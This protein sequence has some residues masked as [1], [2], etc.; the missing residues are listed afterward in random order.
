MRRS[1]LTFAACSAAVA[2]VACSG[3]SPTSTEVAATVG[4]EPDTT[5]VSTSVLASSAA[6]GIHKIAHV[7]VIMQENRSF[8]TYFGTYPGADGIP[9]V[10]G[11]PTVCLPSES[12]LCVAPFHDSADVNGG[13]P[14]GQSNAVSDVAGGKMDGFVLQAEQGRKG[15]ADP[16]NPACTNGS[17]PDVMGWKDAREIPN[18]WAYAQNFVLQDHMFEPNASWSLPEHL[19]M[20]SEWSAHC[21]T[22]RDPSSC[23]NALQ[24]PGSPPD[25]NSGNKTK[26][27]TTTTATPATDAEGDPI[28][29]PTGPDYAW[30]DLTYL[31]HKN[32]VSWGYYVVA[33]N[34]PDCQEDASVSCAPVKQNAKTP[35][36]WNPLPYFDTVKDDGEEAN[37]QSVT[38]FYDQ[39]K[40]GALPAVSWV[41]PSGAVSEH[42]PATS[43]A[44]QAYVTSLINAVMNSPDWGSTAIFLAWDDW[45]GFY[46]HVVPPVVDENGYGLRVP[47]LVISPYAKVGY[48]DHQTLSFDAYVKF[49]EDDFLGGQRLDP[50]TDG[51][52]DPRPDVRENAPQLGDISQAFDFTQ[53]PRPPLILPVHPPPGPPSIPG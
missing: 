42:P 3:T 49:I 26:H 17:H 12:G 48:I 13:G 30:T 7:V 47:G 15:C 31:L 37:V 34:E 50:K 9:M 2:I 41:V 18:Y 40:R 36:I 19:F 14:H 22:P 33:G 5:E 24:N 32:G 38:N 4:V 39:A 25:F 44:G 27:A 53:S 29:V 28:A 20:V 35:G 6:D 52:P 21:T 45:G 51:R 10:D 1:V 23:T 46:D 43:S 8:D 16:T 11:K